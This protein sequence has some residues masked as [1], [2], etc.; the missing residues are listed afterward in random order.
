MSFSMLSIFRCD[1]PMVGQRKS[2]W[3][4]FTHKHLNYALSFLVVY[5]GPC[6]IYKVY[7]ANLRMPLKAKHVLLKLRSYRHFSSFSCPDSRQKPR[8]ED[9]LISTFQQQQ[10][11][12]V[13]PPHPPKSPPPP[14]NYI[15][16]NPICAH[17]RK[18]NQIYTPLLDISGF[19]VVYS[20]SPSQLLLLSFSSSSSSYPSTSSFSS[21]LFLQLLLIQICQIVLSFFER[22]SRKYGCVSRGVDVF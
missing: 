14:P 20:T 5:K 18:R 2:Q 10:S 1:K 7:N 16:P 19:I 15:T 13:P 12:A 8:P 21:L 4:Y 9:I 6:I 11:R 22:D 3:Q 17:I